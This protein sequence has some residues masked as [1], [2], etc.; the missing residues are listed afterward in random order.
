M[1]RPIA[2]RVNTVPSHTIVLT[3]SVYAPARR[4]A[5]SASSATPHTPLNSN[6]SRRN[7]ADE[8]ASRSHAAVRSAAP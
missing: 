8:A 3:G 7:R 6:S 4:A 1:A 5:H 2:P